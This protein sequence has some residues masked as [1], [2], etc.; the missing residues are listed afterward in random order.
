MFC[1]RKRLQVTFRAGFT[2]H[3]SID[4]CGILV[5]A[6][7][8]KM[9]FLYDLEIS[10]GGPEYRFRAADIAGYEEPAEFTELAAGAPAASETARRVRQIRGIPPL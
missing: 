1:R 10:L 5:R 4:V 2:Q 6:W 8:H 3:R 9:Q 7:C